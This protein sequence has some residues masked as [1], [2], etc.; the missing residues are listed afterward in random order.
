MAVR[1]VPLPRVSPIAA[2]CVNWSAVTLRGSTLDPLGF[3]KGLTICTTF[4][5]KELSG[6]VSFLRVLLEVVLVCGRAWDKI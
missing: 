2:H 5:Q 4:V 6:D 1:P 3:P